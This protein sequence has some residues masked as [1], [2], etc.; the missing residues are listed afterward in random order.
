MHERRFPG[1]NPFVINRLPHDDHFF[2]MNPN[3]LA[4]RR[5]HERDEFFRKPQLPR[6]AL[7][8]VPERARF[9]ERNKKGGGGND[10]FRNLMEKYG[11][12]ARVV[13]RDRKKTRLNST[14]MS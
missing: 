14:H 1:R 7:M 11:V 10:E 3:P 6:N 4:G 5:K 8:G 12:R 13:T 2:G 9:F